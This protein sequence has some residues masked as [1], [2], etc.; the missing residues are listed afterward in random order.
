MP[1]RFSLIRGQL[2]S[3]LNLVVGFDELGLFYNILRSPFEYVM[4]QRFYTK[5]QGHWNM[6]R[7]N[8]DFE[9]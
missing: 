3:I 9:W 2:I 6:S 4:I 8:Q 7:F 1:N 5:L